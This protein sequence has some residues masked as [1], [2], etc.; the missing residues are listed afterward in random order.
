VVATFC[1]NLARGLPIQISDSSANID[2]VHVDDVVD[3]FVRLIG[4]TVRGA[5]FAEV[6]PVFQITLGD[7]AAILGEFRA[8]SETLRIADLSDPFRRRLF[9]TYISYL[10][11]D[12]LANPVAA[13]SDRRGELAELLKADG[14][15]QIFLSRTRPGITRGNHYHDLKVEKFIV[16]EGEALIR[17]RHMSTDEQVEYKV[18]GTECRIVDIPPGWTHSIENTGPGDLVTLF[19]SSEVFDPSRP[20]TF[21][22][23]VLK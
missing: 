17:F 16:V 23:E 7:L 22:A 6:H 3:S 9:G 4:I 14:H 2:L 10:P 18:V 11:P 19:W 12:A 21:A 20:D 8:N 15:G 1:H 13:K 5:E